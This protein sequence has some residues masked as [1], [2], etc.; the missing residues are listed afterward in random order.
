LMLLDL[1]IPG[2]DGFQVCQALS[3]GARRLPIIIM[4][5]RTQPHDKI[6]GLELGA[7]DYVTKPFMLAELLA[8]VHAVLRRTSRPA[9]TVTLGDVVV[10]FADMRASRRGEELMLNPREFALLHYLAEHA[11]RVVSR[12]ELLRE[13]WRYQQT[14]LTRAVDMFVA[15]LRRKIEPDP[16]RPRFIRTAHRDG[17]CLVVVDD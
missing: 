11:G 14:P 7:D 13:V 6:R 2:L 4:T 15:R 1:S 3:A 9:H 17:Y 12:E 8:R 10:D 16:Q 5:A